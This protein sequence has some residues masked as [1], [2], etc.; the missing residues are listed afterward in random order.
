MAALWALHP[1]LTESVTN[2]VGRADLLASFGVL[3]GL[4]C[5]TRSVVANG[6]R[7]AAWLV[8]AA[9]SSA[10]G[11]FSKESAIVVL[12]VVPI[13][14]LAFGRATTWRSRLPVYRSAERRVGKE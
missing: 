13:Y 4:V 6:W 5:Y 7:Q 3:A 12:A 2:V 1:L 11:I 9:A 8:A 10:V 14:G